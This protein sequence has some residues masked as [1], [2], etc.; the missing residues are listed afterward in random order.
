[1]T[2]EQLE[3]EVVELAKGRSW[4]IY[5]GRA[6]KEGEPV[7]DRTTISI[8]EFGSLKGLL[9]SSAFSGVGEGNEEALAAIK[10][11]LRYAV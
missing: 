7:R 2:N 5:H 8:Q 11:E 9:D 3:A 1:M 6:K 10:E 4:S